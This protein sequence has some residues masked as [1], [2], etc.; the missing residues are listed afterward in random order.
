MTRWCNLKKVVSPFV[1]EYL[2]LSSAILT[3]VGLAFQANL[4]AGLYELSLSFV[5]MLVKSTGA[6]RAAELLRS[7]YLIDCTDY[8]KH[9][10]QANL[11]ELPRVETLPE[12]NSSSSS[13]SKNLIYYTREEPT[14]HDAFV[15]TSPNQQLHYQEEIKIETL[16]GEIRRVNRLKGKTIEYM[17]DR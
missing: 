2:P 6:F 11:K 8:V 13:S 4:N 15:S 7:K 3:A 1:I 17:K 9:L 14:R 5:F 16:D 10:T 12:L